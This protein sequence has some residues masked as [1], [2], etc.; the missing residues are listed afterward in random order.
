MKT[1]KSEIFTELMN[2]CKLETKGDLENIGCGGV[3][4]QFEIHFSG[5]IQDDYNLQIDEF[6]YRKNNSDWQEC[7]PTEEQKKAMQ[8]FLSNQIE[9]VEEMNKEEEFIEFEKPY[10]ENDHNWGNL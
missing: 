4:N 5:N 10:E 8:A 6:G 3:S 2:N 1:I 7:E 9:V